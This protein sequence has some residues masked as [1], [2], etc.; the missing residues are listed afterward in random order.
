MNERGIGSVELGDFAEERQETVQRILRV[1]KEK[2]LKDYSHPEGSSL[3]ILVDVYPYFFVENKEHRKQ[4]S[5][6]I[7]DLRKI[8]FKVGSVYVILMPIEKILSVKA[9]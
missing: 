4:I 5:S 3:L 9:A 2:S 1:A 6:L 8:D 7:K